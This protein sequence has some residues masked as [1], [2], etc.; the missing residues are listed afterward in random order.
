MSVRNRTRDLVILPEHVPVIGQLSLDMMQPADL[1]HFSAVMSC[2]LS[3]ANGNVLNKQQ[4]CPWTLQARH[5]VAASLRVWSANFDIGN[6]AMFCERMRRCCI[7]SA[8]LMMQVE[9]TLEWP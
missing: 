6:G 1:M 8:L 7:R 4:V 3:L 9:S 5:R 2:H